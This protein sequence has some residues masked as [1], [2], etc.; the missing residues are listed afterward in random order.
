MARLV[1]LAAGLNHR[2]KLRRL[3]STEDPDYKDYLSVQFERA[4]AKRDQTPAR[5]TSILMED[6]VEL[7]RLQPDAR[8]LCVGPRNG[9]ELDWFS[10]HGF[11]D[12]VGIDLFSTRSD[13]LVMDMQRMSFEADT[14]NAV[15]ASHSLEHAYDVDRVVREIVR[16]SKDRAL[17]A[18]EVP[19]RYET[20]GADRHD[21]G[22]SDG[23]VRL[24]RPH[25]AEIIRTDEQPP[26]SPLNASGTAIARALIRIRKDAAN[27]F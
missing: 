10:A 4:Y 22:G 2:L 15:Y 23:L 9:Y 7:G 3:A 24:F 1:E 16:V 5:R 13:I 19:I 25:V 14:F 11:R 18:L 6:L 26:R 27:L 12:A 8:V 20:R 21:F 17:V